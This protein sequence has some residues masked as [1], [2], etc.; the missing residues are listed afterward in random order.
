LYIIGSTKDELSII[1]KKKIQQNLKHEY[2]GKCMHTDKDRYV[3][4]VA[5]S[6]TEMV[7]KSRHRHT[8]S[9]CDMSLRVSCSVSSL[10]TSSA[11][12]YDTH[13]V[14]FIIELNGLAD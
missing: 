7:P 5:S 10:M 12:V 11:A 6:K 13:A 8:K 1:K 4:S 14:S 3:P 2:C 9:S